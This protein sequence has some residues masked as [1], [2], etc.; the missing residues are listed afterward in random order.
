[1]VISWTMILI[2]L[3]FLCLGIGF[4]YWSPAGPRTKMWF[5]FALFVIAT[6]V[7]LYYAGVLRIR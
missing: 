5:V 4:Y 2:L 7:I 3:A 6:F 1:M